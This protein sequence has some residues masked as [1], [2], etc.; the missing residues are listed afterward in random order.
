VEIKGS[1]PSHLFRSDPSL[2]YLT[3]YTYDSRVSSGGAINPVSVLSRIDKECK[4]IRSQA[5]KGRRWAIKRYKVMGWKWT[6]AQLQA[7]ELKEEV[8]S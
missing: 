4:A 5:R 2:D 1:L 8:I 6:L 3:K 7:S